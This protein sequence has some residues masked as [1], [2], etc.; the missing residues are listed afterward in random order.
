MRED[1]T[2]AIEK[3]GEN[4]LDP[5]MINISIS[6]NLSLSGWLGIA[7]P[8]D[9]V[10]NYF[11][12]IE[13]YLDETFET[14]KTIGQSICYYFSGFDWANSEFINLVDTAD[15]ISGDVLT[16][17]NPVL[18][19]QGEVLDNYMGCNVLYIHEF[20]LKPEYR[21]KGIGTMVFP[22]IV[23]I[24]GRDAGIV[25]IIPTPTE[26]DGKKRINTVDPR[27][28]PVYNEMS[29]FIMD[30]GFFC[31]ERENRVWAKDTTLRD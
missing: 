5:H 9:Y 19:R 28:N 31:L 3:L 11:V 17:I 30:F 12:K 10:N 4:N 23:D 6:T 25:T 27:Y 20:Y 16:A 18:N 24:L 29:K 26:N 21:D 1:M 14:K 13:L 7:E 2:K 15:S 22:L 8:G